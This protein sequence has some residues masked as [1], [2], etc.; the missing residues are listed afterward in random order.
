M[1]VA[2][3]DRVREVVA[4]TFGLDA[5]EVDP[6][7]SNQT[8][9]A[10]SSLAHLRLVANLEQAFGVRFSMTELTAMTSIP[11]IEQTLAAKGVEG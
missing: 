7:A 9:A 11:A 10:W 6:H 2:L 4:N 5:A 1:N 8:L 3:G